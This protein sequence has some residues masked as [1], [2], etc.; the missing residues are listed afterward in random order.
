MSDP[1]N[2]TLEALVEAALPHVVFDG[3]TGAAM[4]VAPGAAN[5][6]FDAFQAVWLAALGGAVAFAVTTASV[7]VVN[8]RQSA[9]VLSN[10]QNQNGKSENYSIKQ[11]KCI[12][13]CLMLW[14]VEEP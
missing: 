9:D 2:P 7:M 11:K 13:V 1:V 5:S 4:D 12:K 6:G 10:V 14:K 3:W 8:R